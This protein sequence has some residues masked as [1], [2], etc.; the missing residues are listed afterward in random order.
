MRIRIQ[1]TLACLTARHNRR[2]G[3][4]AGDARLE[5]GGAGEPTGAMAAGFRAFG[6]TYKS[7]RAPSSALST[8]VCAGEA[9]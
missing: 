4:R 9:K 8:K 1:T 2:S 7:E 6:R 5:T 3:I